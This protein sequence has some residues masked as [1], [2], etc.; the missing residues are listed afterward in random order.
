VS[1]F[2]VADQNLT[3]Q[4]AQDAGTMGFTEA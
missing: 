4:L 2:E 3:I 1:A